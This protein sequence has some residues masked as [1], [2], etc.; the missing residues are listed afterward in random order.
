ML[1]VHDDTVSSIF[2]N[3]PFMLYKSLSN[4]FMKPISIKQ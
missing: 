1:Y 2:K 4:P 3:K